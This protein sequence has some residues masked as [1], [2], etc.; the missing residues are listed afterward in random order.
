MLTASL[1]MGAVYWLDD[2]TTLNAT[3]LVVT[4]GVWIA[5]AATLVLRLCS[6]LVGQRLAWCL[7]GLFVIVLCSVPLVS[8]NHSNP[9]EPAT[10]AR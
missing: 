8:G 10:S 6:R 1:A 7:V 9:A 2:T 4:I 3:K 5:Y